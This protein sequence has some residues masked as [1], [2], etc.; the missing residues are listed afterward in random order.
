MSRLGVHK[1]LGEDI[2]G[3]ADPNWPKEYSTPCHTSCS[4]IKSWG[5]KEGRMFRV[6]AFVFPSS[7]YV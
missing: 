6:M 3:T 2:G 5:K 4:A 7:N 1:K